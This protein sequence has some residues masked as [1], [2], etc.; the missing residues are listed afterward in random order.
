MNS[1][2][3]QAIEDSWLSGFQAIIATYD[4]ATAQYGSIRMS[5]QVIATYS[6]PIRSRPVTYGFARRILNLRIN[7]VLEEGFYYLSLR[8]SSQLRSASASTRVLNGEMKW[9]RAWPIPEERI[10][11]GA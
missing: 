9:R 1:A 8:V 2:R 11:G 7:S 5:P 3:M 4:G 10:G 6:D